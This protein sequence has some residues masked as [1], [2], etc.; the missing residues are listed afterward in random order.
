MDIHKSVFHSRRIKM[1]EAQM[2][3]VIDQEANKL[4]GVYRSGDDVRKKV[5]AGLALSLLAILSEIPDD[6]KAKKLLDIIKDLPLR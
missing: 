6:T 3:S 5:K 2:K 1:D 4:I